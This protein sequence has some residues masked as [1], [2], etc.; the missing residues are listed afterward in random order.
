MAFFF[1]ALQTAYD[2]TLDALLLKIMVILSSLVVR[3]AWFFED[4]WWIG[5]HRTQTRFYHQNKE[6]LLDIGVLS[7][8]KYQ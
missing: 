8:C 3:I 6:N 5:S 7:L 4:W 1:M 2:H